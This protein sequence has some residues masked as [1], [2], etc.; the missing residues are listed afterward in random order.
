V[1]SI[2]IACNDVRH[3]PC[4]Q[5]VRPPSEPRTTGFRRVRDPP[6]ERIPSRPKHPMI[7]RLSTT[8]LC[9]R[10]HTRSPGLSA[11]AVVAFALGIGLT[12]AT[13]SILDGDV[14]KGLPIEN[15]NELVHMDVSNLPAGINSVAVSIHDFADRR[16]AQR[17]FT[18]IAAFF[19]R[20]P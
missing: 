12:T 6:Q 7:R 9:V 2:L 10:S 1:S 4:V 19:M 8:R 5:P 3:S 20:A 11:I 17:S 14:V 13:F 16:A 15:A 18:D